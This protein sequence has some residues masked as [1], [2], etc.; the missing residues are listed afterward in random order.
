MPARRSHNTNNLAGLR[1]GLY[2]RVSLDKDDTAKSTTDQVSIGREWAA[3]V[4]AVVV[5]EYVEKG[6]RSA[7]RFATKEREE[8]NRL[9]ADIE[10]GQLDAIWFWEQSRSS[11]R[12][13]VFAELRDTCRRMG[14]LWVERDR[15]M[16]PHDNNDMMMAGFK[17]V[18]SEQE[19]E[20]TSLRVERGKKS[21]AYAGRRAG[22]FTY[23]YR[24][25]YD[26]DGRPH[27]EPDEDEAPIVREVYAR[28]LAGHS[29]GSIRRDLN[30]RGIRTKRGGL[31][32]NRTVHFVATNPSY[33][34]KR[35][36]QVD[37]DTR[38]VDRVT[39]I[40]EGVE[41][42]WPPLIDEETFWTV[43]RILDDPARLKYRRGPRTAVHLVSA[44][45][46]CGVCG[47]KLAVRRRTARAEHRR[48]QEYHC[49][50][51]DCVGIPLDLLDHYVEDM[52]IRW[53]SDP[54]VVA[55][56]TRLDDSSGAASL[57]RGELERLHVELQRLYRDTRSGQ[58]SP[59]IATRAEQ[60]LQERIRTTKQR[61]QEATLPPVLRGN[62]GPQAREG[63]EQ[64]D[65]EVKREIIRVTADIRVQRVGKVGHR[66]SAVP[67]EDRVTWRWLLGPAEME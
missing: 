52:M 59:A 7:S 13:G 61:I 30:D 44:V 9:V 46:R 51:R 6:S 17:A 38:Q 37:P 4:G 53:L 2:C 64:L 39:K 33:I 40:L 29:I 18:I 35:V 20:Q 25:V 26:R 5:G 49:R 58:I 11:R 42:A 50:D 8:F 16:D 45:A 27:D 48:I 12:L 22:R 10:A 15:V 43:H 66:G 57:D 21:S 24:V 62:V 55:E 28:I 23:G 3:R 31:W 1:V 67:P 34:G 47:S 14:V 56:L 63:W 32:T 36:Y 19:S 65:I 54:D 60:G 41:A